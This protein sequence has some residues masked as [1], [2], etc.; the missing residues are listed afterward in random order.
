MS[1][2]P[3]LRNTQ[4]GTLIIGA[5]AA[6]YVLGLGSVPAIAQA[7]LGPPPAY[8]DDPPVRVLGDE[9]MLRMKWTVGCYSEDDLRQWYG[10]VVFERPQAAAEFAVERC[11]KVVWT[12]VAFKVVHRPTWPELSDAGMCIRIVPNDRGCLWVLRDHLKPY[13]PSIWEDMKRR[14]KP[15]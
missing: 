3:T 5:L 9:V 10:L 12:P 4:R 2:E 7:P 11:Q 13:D 14:L 8:L 6:L 15:R 1:N